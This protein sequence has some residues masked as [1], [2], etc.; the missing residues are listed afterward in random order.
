MSGERP[1]SLTH[2]RLSAL[3]RFL[4]EDQDR[5]AAEYERIRVRLTKLF[6]WRGCTTAEEYADTAVDRVARLIAEG[7]D[8]RTPN[9][10]ALFH[11]VAVNLL[12]EHWR[13]VER[14]RQAFD[15]GPVSMARAESPDEVLAR[16]EADLVDEQRR[17]CLQRCLGRLAPDNR[18]LIRRYYAGGQVLDKEQ[19]QTVA[20]ELQITVNALRVRAHRVRGE[21]GECVEGCLQRA[22]RLK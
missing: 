16:R 22:D 7:A 10:Y 3:L 19:R 20:A 5:A 8:V 13:Q 18:A 11:G 2:D 9:R 6:R 14:E 1:W 4:D 15:R 21:I 17:R 12:R